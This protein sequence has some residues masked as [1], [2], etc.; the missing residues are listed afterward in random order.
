MA[1]FKETQMFKINYQVFE[2]LYDLAKMTN[3]III[4]KDNIFGCKSACCNIIQSLKYTNENLDKWSSCIIETNAL[5]R[6]KKEIDNNQWL[7]LYKQ[8][9]ETYTLLL[10]LKGVDISNLICEFKDDYVEFVVLPKYF[11]YKN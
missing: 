9:Q 2:Y 10:W 3:E 8:L 4:E 6:S 11:I 1:K 7:T 5:K